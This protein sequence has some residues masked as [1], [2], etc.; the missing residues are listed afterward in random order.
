[1]K[2]ILDIIEFAAYLAM[3]VLAPAAD[4]WN[5]RRA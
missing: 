1:M 2:Q 4:A 3:A 5:G